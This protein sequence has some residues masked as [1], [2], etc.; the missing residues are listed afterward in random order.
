MAVV[1]FDIEYS[2]HESSSSS[3]SPLCVKIIIFFS[4]PMS[5]ALIL[6]CLLSYFSA[7]RPV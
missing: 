2:P 3:F 5:L 4:I 7:L 6:H 1:R